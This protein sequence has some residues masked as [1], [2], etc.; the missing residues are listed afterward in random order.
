MTEYIVPNIFIIGH[1]PWFLIVLSLLSLFSG[2]NVILTKN[3]VFSVLFLI[4]LFASVS[5][6]LITIGLTFL[7][8]SYLLIYIGAISILFIIILML[9]NIRISELSIE[10]KNG[11]FLAIFTL[12]IFNFLVLDVIPGDNYIY[13]IIDWSK[14]YFYLI[15]GYLCSVNTKF[16]DENLL[17][18]GFE[19]E[20]KLAFSYSQDWE[21]IILPISDIVFVGNILYTNNLILFIILG[22]ILLLSLTGTIVITSDKFT[23]KT[24]DAVGTTITSNKFKIKNLDAVYPVIT[25]DGDKRN[26]TPYR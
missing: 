5:V 23:S 2:L 18:L 3:P 15:V 25:K 4:A 16:K 24:F 19:I 1:K 20:T 8:I 14:Y 9:I 7:G 11:L 13:D 6:Y 22:S 21:G 10:N 26:S 17:N 12:L